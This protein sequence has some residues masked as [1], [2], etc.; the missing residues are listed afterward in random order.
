MTHARGVRLLSERWLSQAPGTARRRQ[1]DVAQRQSNGFVNRR[2]S[3]QVRPSA[4]AKIHNDMGSY[5]SGQTGLTVNQ[6]ALPSEV[7]ILHCPPGR[8][9]FVVFPVGVLP[10]ESAT[11]TV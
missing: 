9:T 4:P 2:L 1:A 10:S 6:L 7:R 3:V 11:L 8:N 5:R